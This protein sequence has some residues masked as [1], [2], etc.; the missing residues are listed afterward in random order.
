MDELKAL[1]ATGHT[2]ALRQVGEVF[3][4][5]TAHSEDGAD[6]QPFMAIDSAG[7]LRIGPYMF[8]PVQAAQIGRFLEN[9]SSV[10]EGHV[11]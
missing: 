5:V 4:I 7:W 10:W 3:E 2:V 9:V 6:E 1:L 8:T 11:E